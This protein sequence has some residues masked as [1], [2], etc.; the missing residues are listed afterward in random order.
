MDERARDKQAAKITIV[1]GQPPGNTR[2]LPPIPAG[3]EE[4]LGLAAVEQQYADLLYQDR[5]HAV[6]ASGVSLTATERVILG[7]VGDDALRKMVDR[8][9]LTEQ[10]RRYFLGRAAA[11]AAVLVAG[12]ATVGAAGCRDKVAPPQGPVKTA[13]VR[14]DRTDHVEAPTGIRP[15]R[16][17]ASR[18]SELEVE[19]GARPDRPPEPP[20]V[21]TGI[22][23]DHPSDH[24]T[25]RGKGGARPDRPKPDAGVKPKPN[26]GV[27]PDRPPQSRGIRPDRPPQTKG[28]RPDRP[29]PKVPLKV[30]NPF[31]EEDE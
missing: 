31:R 17:P 7:A 8:L 24:D 3:I 25:S 10:D 18:P 28:I 29:S 11:V 15:D 9:A 1:G 2:D 22:R 26:R 19:T 20:G 16:P 21:R 27:R 13:G 30:Y 6:E 23:P 4:I 12:A 14:P 5:G